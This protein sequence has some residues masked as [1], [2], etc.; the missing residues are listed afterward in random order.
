M[1]IE[2]A[3]ADKISLSRSFSGIAVSVFSPGDP[4]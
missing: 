3:R 2:M 1:E 4:A